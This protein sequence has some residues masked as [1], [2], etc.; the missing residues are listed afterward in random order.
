MMYLV[1]DPPAAPVGSYEV[2][3]DGMV[4]TAVPDPSG[5]YGFHMDLIALNL[6]DGS[7]T[8]RARAINDWGTSGWATLTFAKAAPSVPANLELSTQ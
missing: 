3:I 2:D 4:Y 6:T 5:K 8:A 7:H 1:C